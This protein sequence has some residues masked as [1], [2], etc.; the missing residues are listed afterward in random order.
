MNY[1]IA[2]NIWCSVIYSRLQICAFVGV[3]LIYLF[4]RLKVFILNF[5]FLSIFL[6][7]EGVFGCYC[8]HHNFSFAQRHAQQHASFAVI[9]SKVQLKIHL[10]CSQK[11]FIILVLLKNFKLSILPLPVL[12][13]S[14]LRD[15]CFDNLAEVLHR[16][17]FINIENLFDE[18]GNQPQR[19]FSCTFKFKHKLD[20][21]KRIVGPVK[22]NVQ[23]FI[24]NIT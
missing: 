19:Y 13:K 20:Y 4:I 12:Q 5:I 21:N 11:C 7:S 15:F 2:F 17:N 23:Y 22:F 8:T 3:S 24:S 18:D 14:S 1:R 16:Q 10:C 9:L 6:G